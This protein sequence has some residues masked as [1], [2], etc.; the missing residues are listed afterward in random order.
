[1]RYY[2]N[3]IN[4]INANILIRMSKVRFGSFCVKEEQDT[5]TTKP[6]VLPI[7][8]TSS[9]D[10]EDIQEG[11]EI[12][13]G[14]KEGHVY[15]RYGNPTV[16]T[17][18][19]KLAKLEVF[20]SDDQAAAVMFSSGMSAISTLLISCLKAGDKVLTQGN[21]YGGTTELFVKV[22]ANFQVQTILTDLS[23]MDQL[24][25][26]I[27]QDPTIKMIYF[28]TPANPS[29]A[30]IDIAKVVEIAKQHDLITVADNTFCTPYLQQPLNMGTDFVLHSTTKYLNGHG[31]GIAGVVVSKDIE[32]MKS[33]VWTNMK[34][35]GTNSNPFD[36]WLVNSGLKTL[37]LRMDRHCDNAMQVATFLQD[38]PKVAYVNYPGL[39]AHTHHDI[40]AGQMSQ[41]GGMLSFEL[42][43][44]LD[45][46]LQ[47]M[48]N[49]RFCTLA[50]TLGDVDTLV[51]HPASSSHINID[52]EIRKANGITDG[53]VRL[54]VGIENVEDII[55]DLAR[56]MGD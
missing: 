53:L 9:F 37:E 13:K 6:H 39:K 21:I 44:G 10:F 15:G 11:I 40:A 48:N 38:H 55:E 47:F 1:M 16:N 56:G 35:L 41:F 34:L 18:E 42:K 25:N 20:G 29:M 51:L 4:S 33:K 14:N 2:K 7:Y 54:S 27:K 22:F 50:P 8:A 43:D 46:G 28:E 30:C 17:I 19:N 12:F 45:A 24:E 49:I 23:D 26:I 36:A 3:S 5:R 52:K 32:F 31:N